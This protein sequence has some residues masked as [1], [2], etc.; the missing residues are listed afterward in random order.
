MADAKAEKPRTAATLPT[1]GILKLETAFERFVGDIGSP[2]SLPYPTLIETVEGA[3]AAKVTS[4]NDDSLLEPF[5]AA[6]RRV[7]AKGAEAISTTC[8]FLV[9]YQRQ[10]ADALPVPVATSS[11]LQVP[12]AQS[13]LP[14]GKKVGIITFDAGNLSEKHLAA[15]GVP[16]GTV[17][18]GLDRDSPSYADIIG[19]GAAVSSDRRKADALSTARQLGAREPDLGAV[20]V[21]CTNIAPYSADIAELLGVPVFDTVTLI[22]WLATAVRPHRYA[23]SRRP[24]G[25]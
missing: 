16:P 8:G 13:L 9:L 19:R 6:G 4:L 11:L 2:E 7:I 17:V 20:V 22:E 25:A 5:I 18:V 14:K 1:I 3:T 12:M 21:E 23:G 24:A 10:L 15:A